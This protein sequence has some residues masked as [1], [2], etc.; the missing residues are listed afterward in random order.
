VSPRDPHDWLGGPDA[1]ASW[2]F[3]FCIACLA[4]FLVFCCTACTPVQVVKQDTAE[5]PRVD[6][7]RVQAELQRLREQNGLMRDLVNGI[8]NSTQ[9]VGWTS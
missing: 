5:I 4:A 9:C 1:P 2:H 7:M 6:I 3:W 8:N